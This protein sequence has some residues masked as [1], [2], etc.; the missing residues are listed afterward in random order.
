MC[1]ASGVRR[2][3]RDVP[4]WA[5]AQDSV[6]RCRDGGQSIGDD[7]QTQGDM[8]SGGHFDIVLH[9]GECRTHAL[10]VIIVFFAA[11]VKRNRGSLSSD[12]AWTIRSS[13]IDKSPKLQKV[14]ISY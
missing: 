14:C 6:G 4:V 9:T 12:A 7:A 11:G 2:F 8:F 1:A 3:D 5:E 10:K 13:P